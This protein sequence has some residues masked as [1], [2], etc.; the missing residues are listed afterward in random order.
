MPIFAMGNLSL[1]ERAMS[2]ATV[3]PEDERMLP[4]CPTEGARFKPIRKR[5]QKSEAETKDRLKQKITLLTRR[6]QQL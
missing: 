2:N 1:D 4:A 6:V 3:A 5:G